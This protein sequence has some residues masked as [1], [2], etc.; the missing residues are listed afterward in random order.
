[1]N[2]LRGYLWSMPE[3]NLNLLRSNYA[4]AM[5]SLITFERNWAYSLFGEEYRSPPDIVLCL[6]WQP[7][8]IQ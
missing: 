2:M 7:I 8:E 3:D 6:S 5:S 1:M 4:A